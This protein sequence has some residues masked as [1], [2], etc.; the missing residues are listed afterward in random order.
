[1]ESKR[2][3]TSILDETGGSIEATKTIIIREK[4]LGHI[5]N[6][7]RLT[8]ANTEI[9]AGDIYQRPTNHLNSALSKIL[10]DKAHSREVGLYKPLNKLTINVC[11]CE[12]LKILCTFSW[13]L[14]FRGERA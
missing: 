13:F 6:D 10:M 3:V 8:D 12:S 5:W 9:L 7:D 11:M 4:F 2:Q 1:M 14:D